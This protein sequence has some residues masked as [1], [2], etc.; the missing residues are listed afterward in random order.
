MKL[1]KRGKFD[2]DTI[3]VDLHPEPE[4]DNEDMLDF[5]TIYTLSN[6]GTVYV[7]EPEQVPD[8]APSA[9]IFRF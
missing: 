1:R 9:A 2:P 7:V 6:G 8:A 5:V 3:S 4:P